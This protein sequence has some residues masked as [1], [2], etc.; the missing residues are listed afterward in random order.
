MRIKFKNKKFLILGAG[1]SGVSAKTFIE[2]RKGIAE[3]F[4]DKEPHDFETSEFNYVVLSPAITK[5]HALL[6]AFT[7][8]QIIPEF[9]LGLNRGQM[10]AFAITGTNGKTT[11]S[12]NLAR[13]LGV[14]ACGNIGLPTTSRDTKER[15]I[16]CEISSFMLEHSRLSELKFHPKCAAILN[17]TQDHL[18]RHGTMGEYIDCKAF[19]VKLARKIVLNY[20][21]KN[22]RKIGRELKNRKKITWFSTKSTVRGYFFKNGFIYKNCGRIKKIA[23]IKDFGAVAAHDIAN[24][25]AVLSMAGERKMKRIVKA[26]DPNEK[27]RHRGEFVRELNGVSYY[28]DSKATNIGATLACV[29]SFSAP[30]YL[31]LGGRSKGQ[32]F[33][34]LFSKLP[35]NVIKTYC[36]GES[37][38]QLKK[39]G[40]EVCDNMTAALEKARN[41]AEE[42]KQNAVVLLSPACSSLDE[43]KSYADRGDLFAQTVCKF[44]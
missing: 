11:V 31:L 41:D 12:R 38:K 30:I 10:R 34:E 32:D 4:D 17:I 29:N 36:F 7:P 2:K 5:D 28:N 27:P 44:E 23:D 33:A 37:K 40:C 43:F 1:K 13:A 39:F 24:I 26:F 22:C 19:A 3:I 21:D 15:K 6:A 35:K 8:N 16:V 9:M 20:D 25:L 14:S 18:D 42:T